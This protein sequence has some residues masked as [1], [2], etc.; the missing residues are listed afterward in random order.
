M[1]AWFTAI[2]SYQPGAREPFGTCSVPLRNGWGGCVLLGRPSYYEVYALWFAC[3]FAGTKA[4]NLNH[5]LPGLSPGRP[6]IGG[7]IRRKDAFPHLLVAAQGTNE[8]GTHTWTFGASHFLNQGPWLL[9]SQALVVY[10]RAGLPGQSGRTTIQVTNVFQPSGATEFSPR[11]GGAE[12][13]YYDTRSNI[14]V[15]VRSRT[16]PSS[17]VLEKA[18]RETASLNWARVGADRPA[19][20]PGFLPS[21]W[22]HWPCSP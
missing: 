9:P 12:A 10:S 3:A 20:P 15:R 4:A 1:A 18:H 16:W 17:D 11:L 2:V 8:E 21:S 13:W 22:D 14:A 19:R 6:S 5:E 7:W